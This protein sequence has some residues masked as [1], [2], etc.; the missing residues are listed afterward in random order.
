[1][2]ISD[3]LFRI[4]GYP[5]PAA[6]VISEVVRIGTSGARI[7]KITQNRIEYVDMSEQISMTTVTTINREEWDADSLRTG[8]AVY[9]FVSINVRP[10]WAALILAACCNGVAAVPKPVQHVLELARDSARWKLAHD[11]FSAVRQLTLA[12]ERQPIGK[13]DHYLL[14][15]A[16][17]AAKVIYNASGSSAPFDE[18][19]GAWLVRCAKEF[20][21]CA[22]DASFTEDLW[23]IITTTLPQ[24]N[25]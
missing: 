5:K 13:L 15:V 19:C 17:N 18:D 22:K 3:W 12:A 21:D 23:S 9:S 6:D 25:A 14:Y 2:S 1:M 7:V 4:V 11:A 8:V 16:E 10:E 20:A 24:P